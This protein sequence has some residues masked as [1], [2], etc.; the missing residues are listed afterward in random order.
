[1]KIFIFYCL[2]FIHVNM[3]IYIM[4]MFIESPYCYYY[5]AIESGFRVSAVWFWGWVITRIGVRYGFGFRFWVR[6]Y[7]DFTPSKSAPLPSLPVND[8]F[9]AQTTKPAVSS[10]LHT[11]PLPL[12]TCHCRPRLA[13]LP[14]LP[15]PRLTRTSGVLTWSTRSL[16][17]TFALVDIP[18][19]S[20]RDW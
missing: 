9:E 17:C 15:E 5:V 1:M 4:N 8:G 7:R 10:V 6:V 16:P 19:V 14:S 3:C 13:G 2:L 12:N 18:D 20:H 11:H